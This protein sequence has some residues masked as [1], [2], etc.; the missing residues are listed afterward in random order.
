MVYWRTG[1]RNFRGVIND[2]AASVMRMYQNNFRDGFR[3]TVIG[4]LEKD[5]L[6]SDYLLGLQSFDEFTGKEMVA[7][8]EN[9]TQA[10]ALAAEALLHAQLEAIETS[11]RIVVP[12]SEIQMAEGWVVLSIETALMR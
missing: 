12:N 2:G 9:E 10:A 5:W 1:K 3:Q 7:T 4:R 11:K 6:N 8:G